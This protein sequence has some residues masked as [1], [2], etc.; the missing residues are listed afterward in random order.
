[1]V[2]SELDSVGK[3]TFA[4]DML[5]VVQF[6]AF[7]PRDL[8]EFVDMSEYTAA[9]GYVRERLTSWQ[10]PSAGPIEILFTYRR[11]SSIRYP[12]IDP[13]LTVPQLTVEHGSACRLRSEAQ[14]S[15]WSA[16]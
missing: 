3:A 7:R 15:G 10:V 13:G 6:P 14:A 12:Y 5:T 16:A 2:D 11:R 4:S 1:M 9:S 8:E